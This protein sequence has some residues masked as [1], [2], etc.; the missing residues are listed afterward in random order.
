MDFPPDQT[1][2]GQ[3]LFNSGFRRDAA[4]LGK[5]VLDEFEDAEYVVVP[6]GS[7]ASMMKVFY[8]EIFRGDSEY[9]TRR[10]RL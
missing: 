10:P 4:E 5:R 3:P 6:S 2:C 9:G 8:P 1:C 7:C